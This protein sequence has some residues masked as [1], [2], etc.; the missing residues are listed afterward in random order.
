MCKN[1]KIISSVKNGEISLCKGCKTY[2]LTFK[3]IFFQ[4]TRDQLNKF[5]FYV[6]QIDINY[7]LDYSAFSTQKRKIPIPTSHENL[8]L[9][10]DIHEIKELRTLLEIDQKNLFKLISASE[11]D[12]PLILN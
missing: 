5:K 3:N 8:I 7:W 1:S 4:F 9:V 10:F 6:A 2:A 11:I 12:V